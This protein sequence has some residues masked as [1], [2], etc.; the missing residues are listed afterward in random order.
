MTKNFKPR[1]PGAQVNPKEAAANVGKHSDS[2]VAKKHKKKRRWVQPKD[3]SIHR[4]NFLKVRDAK[5]RSE[6]LKL[7]KKGEK[8]ENSFSDFNTPVASAD[9]NDAFLE[10]LLDPFAAK[11]EPT[12]SPSAINQQG[13]G[14]SR[15]VGGKRDNNKAQGEEG[16]DCAEPS[17]CCVSFEKEREEKCTEGKEAASK[18]AVRDTIKGYMPF[19]KAQQLFEVKQKEKEMQRAARQEEIE[20]ELRRKKEKEKFNKFANKNLRARTRKGQIIMKNVVDVLLRKM[21]RGVRT[22]Q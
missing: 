15:I 18:G 2:I 4:K 19:I 20:K 9:S 1:P 5:A 11:P 12:G 17:S 14:K 7:N 16:G 10:Q 3:K 8:T 22:P 21:Q 13:R 6:F